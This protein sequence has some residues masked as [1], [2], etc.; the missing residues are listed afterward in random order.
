MIDEATIIECEMGKEH[1][2]TVVGH[3]MVAEKEDL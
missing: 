1:K 2:S 3:N